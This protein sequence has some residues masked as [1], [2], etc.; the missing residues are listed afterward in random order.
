MTTVNTPSGGARRSVALTAPQPTEPN[1]HPA[2]GLSGRAARGSVAPR[3]MACRSRRGVRHLLAVQGHQRAHRSFPS[4]RRNA[5]GVGPRDRTLTVRRHAAVAKAEAALESASREP[6]ATA[7]KI[8]KDRAAIEQRAKAEEARWN[9]AKERLQ[10]ALR[11][12]SQ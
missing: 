4:P 3:K 6:E 11:K 7:T 9:K 8:Q 5:A 10:A 2:V 12:A 1:A